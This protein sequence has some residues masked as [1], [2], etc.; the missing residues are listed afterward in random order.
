VTIVIPGSGVQGTLF[1]VRLAR[2]GHSVTLVA[3]GE[4]AAELGA[5]GA[6]VRNAITG[7][8]DAMRLPVVERL[9][10]HTR[11]DLCFV[12][13]QR[14]QIE[15]TLSDL[16]AACAIERIIFMVSHANGSDGLFAA[17]GR[18][19]IVLGFPSAAGSIE[20]GVDVYVDVAE[21]P[22][23]IEHTAPDIAVI[24]RTAGFRVQLVTDV[25][26][27]LKR[28]AV[29]VT[30]VGGALYQK[31]GDS[32]LLS[33]DKKLVRKFIFAVR[34]GWS[35]LDERGVAPAPLALRTIFSWV[36][37]PLAIVYWCRFFGSARGEYYF[38]RHTRHATKEMAALVADV[39][40]LVLN[41]ETPHLRVLYGAIDRRCANSTTTCSGELLDA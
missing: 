27:W 15:E 25:D 20:N 6:A 29:F 38:A 21:Q 11:A 36:P 12:L 32:G 3:R 17:L 34:E 10:S 23:I 28:H 37:L 24:L 39:R 41:H 9:A 8:R 7:R 22:M 26:S 31:K 4:R 33:S 18:K 2:A 40:A 35:A 5:Q 1:G 14:E 16:K 19:R 13:V 30:A